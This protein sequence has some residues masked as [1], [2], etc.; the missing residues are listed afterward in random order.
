MRR[1]SL[2][3]QTRPRATCL[4]DF[5]HRQKNTSLPKETQ[6]KL[7]KAHHGKWSEPIP[8]DELI[9]R[10]RSNQDM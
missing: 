1:L 8:L 4:A 2:L 7:L 10:L 9:D 6:R 5:V 3:R